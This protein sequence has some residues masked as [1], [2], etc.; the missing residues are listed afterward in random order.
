MASRYFCFSNSHLVF[1]R[2]DHRKKLKVSR[3]SLNLA[4]VFKVFNLNINP[5]VIGS[6]LFRKLKSI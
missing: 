3:W 5:L 1:L 6:N 2:S 4:N